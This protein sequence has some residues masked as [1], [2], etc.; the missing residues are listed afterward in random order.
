MSRV[1]QKGSDSGGMTHP[2]V[3]RHATLDYPV[4]LMKFGALSEAESELK[5]LWSAGQLPGSG[6]M[7]LATLYRAR[8]EDA[9]ASSLLR[10]S[11]VLAEL[12]NPANAKAYSEAF[13]YKYGALIRPRRRIRHLSGMASA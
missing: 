2:K 6:R 13:P 9:K 4:M 7:L 11:G 3:L 12:P 1:F 5:A 8:G 10:R